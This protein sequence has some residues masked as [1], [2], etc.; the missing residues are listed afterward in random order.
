M[1][2]S[3]GHSLVAAME[4]S[5]LSFTDVEM[6]LHYVYLLAEALPVYIYIYIYLHI[7]VHACVRVCF[8]LFQSYLFEENITITPAFVWKQGPHMIE[9][10]SRVLEPLMNAI[11]A[12]PST[13]HTHSAVLSQVRL[14]PLT[15]SAVPE[16]LSAESKRIRVWMYLSL[17]FFLLFFLSN[18]HPLSL[19]H[20]VLRVGRSV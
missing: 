4:S 7:N 3:F 17:P 18:L 15:G 20:I 6:V 9:G 13:Q 5:R 19:D 14:Q 16:C 12:S 10:G 11:M 2:L 1:V 8:F